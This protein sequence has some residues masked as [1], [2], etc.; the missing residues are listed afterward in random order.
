MLILSLYFLELDLQIDFEG[1][2]LQISTGVALRSAMM[3]YSL[4][5]AMIRG[6]AVGSTS[7]TT[8]L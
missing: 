7:S 5:P 3:A 4:R 2:N 6:L 1:L 8:Q